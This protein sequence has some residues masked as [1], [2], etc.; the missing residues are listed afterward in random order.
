MKNWKVSLLVI[1][2]I[3]AVLCLSAGAALAQDKTIS[4]DGKGIITM[5]PDIVNVSVAINTERNSIQDAISE[6]TLAVENVR[7]ALIGAGVSADDLITMNYSVW[8]SRPYNYSDGDQLDERIYSVNYYLRIVV[9]DVSMLNKIL[10]AAVNNG[11]SNIDSVT[12]DY[13]DKS[14]LYSEARKLALA[15]ARSKADAI[16]AELGKTIVDV[17]A[18][19]APEYSEISDM[20]Y[21][22]IAKEGMGGMGGASTPEMTSGA[23]QVSVTLKVGYIFE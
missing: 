9:R 21:N 2:A 5:D 7:K 3:V 10:D 6:N 1:S 19:E 20:R 15:D 11:I 13:S 4:V 23:F 18:V 14:T 8:S 17:A 12:Y 22:M 16:A